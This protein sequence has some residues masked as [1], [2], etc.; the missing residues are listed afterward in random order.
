M[1]INVPIESLEERYSAQWNK[2]FPQEFERLDMEYVTVYGE[3]LRDKIE[4][5]AFLDVIST[6]HFKASQLETLCKMIQTGEIQDG[7][8][9]FFHDL[10]FPGLEMLAYIR[11][12]LGLNIKICGILHAGTYLSGDFITRQ[13]MGVWGS[14][15]ERGWLEF[16]DKVFVATTYHKNVIARERVLP[17]HL[18]DKIHVTGLPI[19]PEEFVKPAKTRKNIVVFP[20]R[21]DPEKRPEL[22]DDVADTLTTHSSGVSKWQ[23]VKTKEVTK[24]KTEYYKLLNQAK[25][26]LSFHQEETWGI[27]QMEALFCGCIPI[28][29]NAGSYTELYPTRLL[30]SGAGETAALIHQMLTDPAFYDY[31]DK[32]AAIAR[33]DLAIRTT[34]AIENIVKELKTCGDM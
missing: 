23:F 27:A 14:W 34:T 20:H 25:I 13:G 15:I 9:I 8:T 17:Q 21:L 28:S 5:G 29:I 22:F 24:D 18:V 7:D 26:S 31:M 1:L 10:W 6:N 30:S 16:V 12:G 33:K 11:D 19:Y 4:Q 32:T 2:W 3:P